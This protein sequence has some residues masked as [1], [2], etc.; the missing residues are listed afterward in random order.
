MDQRGKLMAK[1]V[2]NTYSEERLAMVF[3]EYGEIRNAMKV[4]RMIGAQRKVKPVAT[5]GELKELLMPFAV[6]GR[7]NK[8]FAQVFQALR[9]E[10]NKEMEALKEFLLQSTEVL[11]PGG[12]LVVISYHSLEDKLVKNFF[13]SGKFT[14]D[15]EKDFYGN[16]ITPLRVVNRKPIVA[17]EA[18]VSENPRARSGRLRI[19]EKV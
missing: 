16:L 15:A 6:R 9:I 1:D 18:E 14:G 12:R 8:Y 3:N 2:L 5:T 4:A 17:G 13:R 11:K 10:V 19:A 7:E